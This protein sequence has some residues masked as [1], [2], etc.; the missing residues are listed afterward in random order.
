MSDFHLTGYNA[1]HFSLKRNKSGDWR[2]R[3][4][5]LVDANCRRKARDPSRVTSNRTQ[6]AA[7]VCVMRIFTWLRKDLGFKDL[8]NPYALDERHFLSLARHIK[9]KRESG[10]Y[11]AANAAGLATYCRHLARWIKKP[12]MVKVFGDELGQQVCKRDPVADT[13]KSWEAAGVDFQAK[14]L[15]IAQKVRWVAL[16]LLAQQAFGLR[17]TEALRL[18]PMR[19]LYLIPVLKAKPSSD[20]VPGTG[21]GRAKRV[22]RKMVESV[23]QDEIYGVHIEITDGSKGGR[24]RRFELTSDWAIQ[25]AK[26]LRDEVYR[27]NNGPFLPPAHR[28][29][30]QNTDTYMTTLAKF[31][32]TKKE[33]GVTGHGLRAGFA[34]DQLQ[35][36]D[37]TPTVRGGD[38]Q[39]T[40]AEH[41]MLAYTEVTEAMGHG[42]ISVMG[43]YAG[44][45][46]PTMVARK[47]KKAERQL[48]LESQAQ[49]AS[50]AQEMAELVGGTKLVTEQGSG[51]VTQNHCLVTPFVTQAKQGA[52]S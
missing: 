10:K 9:H 48:M 33:L 6:V 18:Q 28:T 12:E 22:G 8:A 21:T 31:G 35:A 36:R 25:S 38:G 34:C 5:E 16:V 32:L 39:H 26:T 43:A 47:K 50:A 45:I 51:Y 24:P 2:Y 42:R 15:E 7:H 49:G 3:V 23:P 27:L 30:K 52:T 19:D 20:M 40:D 46:T 4:A 41:Q 13:D 37:I 17:R 44:A 1:T 29:L 11:G 14:V